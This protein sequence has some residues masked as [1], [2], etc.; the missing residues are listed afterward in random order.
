MTRRS[1]AWRSGRKVTSAGSLCWC[2]L[3]DSLTERK[4]Q[5]ATHIYLG[6]VTGSDFSL[7]GTY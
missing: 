2:T 1:V 3:S 5:A 4:L 6:R 7:G